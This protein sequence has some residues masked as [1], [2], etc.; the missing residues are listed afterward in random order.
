M[1][2]PSLPVA[3]EICP[4]TAMTRLASG[5]LL[6]DVREPAEV[7]ELAFDVPGSMQIPLSELEQRFAEIPRDRDVIVACRG[8]GRSLKATYFLMYQGFPRVTNMSGGILRWQEKGF[9]TRGEAGSTPAPQAG[10]CCTPSPSGSGT[11]C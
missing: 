3:Q 10:G 4:T 1:S 8:G 2:A 6:V 5:A 9:P 7:A 11:C